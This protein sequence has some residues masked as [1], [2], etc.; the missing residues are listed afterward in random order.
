MLRGI[1][2]LSLVYDVSAGAALALLRSE[3]QTWFGVAAPLPAIHGDLNAIF[4]T[5]VGVGYLLPFR[6]PERNR[7]YLWIF[8]VG[9]KAAG[10]AAFA[11]DYFVRGSP[12][13]FLLFAASDAAVAALTLF[14]LVRDD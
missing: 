5:C 1:A 13:A 11:L 6:D 2:L 9:L 12:L 7:G 3:L 10:A 14:A 8:G 4:V